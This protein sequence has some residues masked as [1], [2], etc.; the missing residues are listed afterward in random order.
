MVL[1]ATPEQP[2]LRSLK[3]TIETMRGSALAGAGKEGEAAAAVKRAVA[4]REKLAALDP[5]YSYDLACALALQARLDLTAPGP[6][7]AAIAALKK[8]AVVGFDN[9]YKLN[10]DLHLEP[11]RSRDDFREVMELVRKNSV[12]PGDSA[13][14]KKH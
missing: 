7:L 12:T 14:G 6:P 2:R 4:T 11:I 10:H 3:A 8:A 5:S 9:V 1:R 13:D